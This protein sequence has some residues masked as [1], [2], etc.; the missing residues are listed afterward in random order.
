MYL[1]LLQGQE[2]RVFDRAYR[3]EL[4]VL[5]QS[6]E[7]AHGIIVAEDVKGVGRGV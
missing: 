3:P 6:V 2:L 1:P 4:S 5:P 7:E